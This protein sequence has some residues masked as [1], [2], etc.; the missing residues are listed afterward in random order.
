MIGLQKSFE[1]S[2][3][4]TTPLLQPRVQEHEEEKKRDSSAREET[5]LQDAIRKNPSCIDTKCGRPLEKDIAKTRD[6]TVLDLNNVMLFNKTPGGGLYNTTST[7]SKVENLPILFPNLT[8]LNLSHCGI[9]SGKN[10]DACA[11]MCLR[12]VAKLTKLESLDLTFNRLSDEAILE[13]MPLTKL[14]TLTIKDRTL[15]L[16][17]QKKLLAAIPGLKLEM[18]TL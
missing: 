2:A 4:E 18:R 14:K 13:L 15:S 12:Q 8:R 9:G 17:A 3:T 11:K 16:D 6:V 10:P 1:A 5:S 7:C